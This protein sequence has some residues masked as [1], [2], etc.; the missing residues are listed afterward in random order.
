M[1]PPAGP[2]TLGNISPYA[3][4]TVKE[5]R[6]PSIPDDLEQK[7]FREL[8]PLQAGQPLDR[9]RLRESIQ[10]LYATGRFADLRAEAERT[11][12]GQVS[13]A[14]VTSANFFVGVITVEGTPGHPTP[15]QAV[16]ACKLQLGELFT[17]EK[18]ERALSNLKQLMEENG[19]YRS[20]VTVTKRNIPRSSRS[21]SHSGCIRVRRRK[22]EK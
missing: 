22:W 8:I 5:I 9:D 2:P 18:I 17:S 12:D 14:F 21:Q 6:F 20:S 3:G 11:D 7:R 4:L 10:K 19:Y 16:N 15:S 1:E 13:V